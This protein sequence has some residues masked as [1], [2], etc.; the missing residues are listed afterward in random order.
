LVKLS[1]IEED[2]LMEFTNMCSYHSAIALSSLLK[3]QV[4]LNINGKSIVSVSDKEMHDDKEPVM[5]LGI[6][7]NLTQGNLDGNVVI[8]FP[9]D[10]ALV[11][12]DALNK[13]RKKT[14]VV[15]ESVKNVLSEIGNVVSGKILGI[16]NKFLGISSRHSI[17]SVVPSFGNHIYDYVYFN[18]SEKYDK[19]I[20]IKV[21]VKFKLTKNKTVEG[22][23]IL[24]LSHKSFNGLLKMINKMAG[25]K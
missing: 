25:G 16:L 22:Q 13:K 1:K 23:I 18:I 24:L 9:K 2:A 17:P 14:K 10:S 6:Y 7:S 11:L 15:D 8:V 4:E 19:G 3:K 12:Y 20:L 5:M 21:D